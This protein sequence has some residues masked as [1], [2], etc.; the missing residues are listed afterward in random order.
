MSETPAMDDEVHD[1]IQDRAHDEEVVDQGLVSNKADGQTPGEMLR[2][3]RLACAYSVDE[4]CRQTMLSSHTVEALEDDRYED[5][6]QPVF[7]R[8][9]FRKCAKVL[10]MDADALM[11]A[12]RAS[13]GAQ[14]PTQSRP[15]ASVNIIPADVTPDRRRT[16]GTV[17]LVIILLVAAFAVY[18]FWA[19]MTGTTPSARNSSTTHTS[20]AMELGGQNAQADASSGPTSLA[21]ALTSSGETAGTKTSQPASTKTNEQAAQSATKTAN[22]QAANTAPPTDTP[23]S[24]SSGM[25]TGGDTHANTAV[26]TSTTPQSATQQ[27]ETAQTVAGAAASSTLTLEFGERSWVDIHDA[28]GKQ[29]LVGIYESTTRTLNGVPPYKLVIGYAPGVDVSLG[30]EPVDYEVA[31]NNTAR[32]TVGSSNG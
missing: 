15:L 11:E 13:G 32:F 1:Y 29:L 20:L 17:F 26:A 21:S 14:V 25:A 27:S 28:T 10:D 30:G 5:L 2:E 19:G 23:E 12:Y 16:F 22:G 31:D 18:L 8:G 6:S 9:Y 3:A 7:A 24:T 4:L